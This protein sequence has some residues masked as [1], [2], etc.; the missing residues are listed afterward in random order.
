LGN[1]SKSATRRCFVVLPRHRLTGTSSS[2]KAQACTTTFPPF[3]S[4][5]FRSIS[6]SV[7]CQLCCRAQPSVPTATAHS[8][9]CGQAPRLRQ[10]QHTPPSSSPVAPVTM[11]T[12]CTA[13]VG[14][15]L[16]GRCQLCSLTETLG[17]ALLFG[18]GSSR[19][20]VSAGNSKLIFRIP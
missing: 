1:P 20:I 5:C 2:H 17:S 6:V 8:R 9:S 18:G 15:S 13:V 3:V 14:S 12:A 10:T 11:V 16:D 4:V 7:R 19:A